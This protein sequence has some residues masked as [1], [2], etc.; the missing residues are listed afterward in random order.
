MNLSGQDIRHLNTITH[1]GKVVI[2]GTAADGT[3]YYSVKRGGFEDTALLEGAD[4]FGFEDWKKLRLG[5]STED[6]SV[7]AYEGKYLTDGAGAPLLRSVYGDS[8]EVTRSAGAPVQLVSALNHLYVFRQSPS[9]KILVSRFVLD[10]MTNELVPR[11]EVRFRRSRQRFEPQQSMASADGGSFDSLDYRDMAGKSFFEPSLELSFAGPVANGWFSAILVPTAESDRKRWHLFVYEPAAAKLVLYSVGSGANGLFDVKDYLYG[12]ADPAK[13]EGATYRSIPGILRRKID[14]QGLTVAGGPSAATYDIQKEQM[15]DAGP[16]LMRDV[17]RAMLAVPVTAGE[18]APVRTAVLD[19]ALAADGTLSQIDLSP[20]DATILRSDTREVL[21]PLSLLDDIKEIAAVSPPPAG[22]VAAMERG[23]DDQLQIRSTEPLPEVLATGA[24]VKLRGSQSY[25]GHYKVLSV[26]GTTFEVAATFQSGEAG[27]WEVAPEKRTGLVF[28]NMVVGT[29]KTSDGKLRVL[30]PAHDLKAGDEVQI[31]GTEGYDGIF[32]VTSIDGEARAFVLDAPFFTGEAANLSKVV[33]RGLRMDGNDRVETPELPLPLPSHDRDLGRTLS[34]WVRIDGAGGVEQR[35]IEDHG[36]MTSL[37]VGSD[38][39]VTLAVRMSDGALHTVTDPDAMPIGAWTHVAGT[40]DYVTAT[41]GDTRIALCR[42]GALAAEQLV[43]HKLPC[44]FG[45]QLIN[46]DGVNDYVEV[47]GFLN[48]TKEFTI[49]LWA[50]SET[51]TWNTHGMLASKRDAFLICPVQGNRN[52]QFYVFIGGTVFKTA[53]YT[54]DDIRIWH[55]YTGTYD[56]K[57]LRFY[58][59]GKLVQSL[60]AAGT[61]GAD[62]GVLCI[63]RDDGLSRYFSGRIAGVELWSRARSQA[64]LEAD[65]GKRWTGREAGLVGYWPLDNGTAKDLSTAK[66]HGSIKGG[67]AWK[68]APTYLHPHFALP[69]RDGARSQVMRF[70][71]YDAHIE[72]PPF[73]SPTSAITV[74][75]WARSALPTWNAWGCLASKRSA[76]M[77]HP[78]AGERKIDFSLWINGAQVNAQFTPLDIQGWHLYTGTY[79]GSNVRLYIDGVQVA[80][81][82]ASGS[83]SADAEGSLYIGHDDDNHPLQRNFKGD[84]AEVQIFDVARSQADI[85]ADMSR[86]LSGGESGLVGYWP[87]SSGPQDLSQN[88]RH[89]VMKGKPSLVSVGSMFAIGQGLSG[90]IADVQIWDRARDADTI[91]ATMHLQLTGKEEGLLANYRMGAIVYEESPP[92]VP[93]FS[94]RGLNGLVY[95]DPYAGARRLHRATGS[96][97][98][99]VQYGSDELC[100]VSQR[101]VYEESFEF[102][103]TSPDPAFNPSNAD[104]TGER[105]FAFSYWGKSSRG[106]KEIA[107]FPA[108][109]VM[110]SDFL[111][112][113]GGWYKAACRVVVPDGVS[114]MRAFEIA[115]VRGRWGQEAA[116]PESEW[117]AI[118]IRKHRI[119]LISDAVT[120]ESYTDLAALA[121]L[122]AQSQAVLDNLRSLRRAEDKVSRF[123]TQIVDLLARIDVVQNN[124]RYVNERNALVARVPNLESQKSVATSTLNTLLNDPYNYFHTLRVKHSQMVAD[125][126]E[127]GL[128]QYTARGTDNQL[129]QLLP[130]GDGSFK[131][132]CKTKSDEPFIAHPFMIVKP[133]PDSSK[134]SGWEQ[135]HQDLWQRWR[136]VDAGDGYHYVALSSDSN[137]VWDVK[138]A[139][140]GQGTEVMTWSRNGGSHQRW[141]RVKTNELLPSA[142]DVIAQQNAV[143]KKFADEIAA[144]QAR[145]AWLNEALA[146]NETLGALQTQLSTA[147]SSLNTARTELATVNTVLLGALGQAAP[148]TMPVLATDDRDLVTAGAVLDFVQPAGGVQLMES[149]EG[150]VLLSYIDTQGRMRA[151]AYDATADSRNAAFEQWSPD[152][153]RA[154]ADIRDSGDKIS[155]AQPVSLPSY[156]WTCE[157]FVQLPLATRSDGTPY[158]LSLVAAADGRLDAPLAV[159]RGSRLGLLLDGWFFDCGADLG[160][161]LAPGWHHLAASTSRG[162]TSFYAN[163]DLV[164]SCKTTQPAL[165]FNGTSDYVEVP[166]FSNPTS[167]M[168]VSIWARSATPTWNAYGCLVSK[169]DAFLLHPEQDSRRISFYVWVSGA[170]LKILSYTP[171]DIQGWH[172][173]T[174]TFDGSYM[175]LYI[176]GAFAAELAVSGTIQADP[177]EMHIGHD[178]DTPPTQRLFGGEIAEVALWNTARGPSEVRE[179]FVR[180]LKG[181]ES[182]LAGYWRMDKIEEGGTL[183]VKDLTSKAHHGLLRGA[184]SDATITT[185]GEL[186]VKVLGNA[187][188]GG[189]P[190]GRLAEVR[191]WNL[192]LSDAEVAAHARTACSGS[193]PGLVG[194]WPLDEATG[195]T[196]RD[197]AAGGELHGAMIGVDWMGCTANIGNPGARV[198]SLPERGNAHLLC[199]NVALGS[200]SFTFECWARRSGAGLGAPQM[201]A[202]MGLAATGKGFGFGFRES[203][204]LT[205]SFHNDDLTSISTYTDTDW[206]HLCGTYDQP[207]KR[208][209]LYVDGALVA[210]RTAAADYIG[211]GALHI[212]KSVMTG[213]GHFAGDLAEVRIWDKARS[214]DEIR[215][216]MRLRLFGTEENLLAHYPMDEA[217]GEGRVRDKK[218]GDWL[219]QLSGTAKLLLSTSLPMAGAN[220]LI[221]AE[222]SSVEVSGEGKKQAL[223]R[224]FSGYASAGLVVLVPEQ[225]VEELA[226]QWVGNTQISPTLLGYIEGPPPVPSENFT[227]ED[228]YDGAATITLSQSDETSYTFQRSETSTSAFNLAAFIGAEW[229][230]ESGIGINVKMTSGYAGAGIEFASEQSV[231][232]DTTLSAVSSLLSSDSLTLMGRLEERAACPAVGKRWVPKNVGY[233]LVV[234]GMADVFVTK[235]KRSGRMVSYEIRPV[236]GVPLD[237]NTITFMLNPAYVLNGSLDGLVGSMPADSIF[238]AHVPEMRAQYGSLYPASYFRLKDAYARKQA[239]QEQDMARDSF[240]Y[241]FSSASRADPADSRNAQDPSTSEAEGGAP[242]SEAA[243]DAD[244]EALQE[245]NEEKKKEA[246]SDSAKRREE[247][248]KKQGSIEGRTRATGA[249]EEWQLR[250]ANIRT[251]AGKRN[252][253]NTYVWDADGGLRAEE[254]SFANTVEHSFSV[255]NIFSLSGGVSADFMV[256]GFKAAFSLLGG[257]SQA[258]ANSRTLG[259][260]RSLELTVDLSGVE[261]KGVTDLYDNPIKPGEKVDRYRFMTFYLENSTDHFSDFWSY[262]VDPEWLMSNDEEARALRQARNGRPN[263]CWRVMHRVTYVERPAL[264]VLG[265]DVRTLAAEEEDEIA[266]GFTVLNNRMDS[267][268]QQLNQVLERLPK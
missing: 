61:V 105:L 227:V 209:R 111:S 122:P 52:V 132:T 187:S 106:S 175:R 192:G 43:R 114:L 14:L 94:R 147:Q 37:S 221:A 25:D 142:R 222:Y 107:R 189:C 35:L 44:Q 27:T 56:G 9:S 173:Y 32:P 80:Q 74:S 217:S 89:G 195:T 223:M 182:G 169:R 102:R 193:E 60:A 260:S 28:D 36:G 243:S 48:P 201:I 90:E 226:L 100:A 200:K 85:Q 24:R 198:L 63:G 16:Q 51:S 214:L 64:E 160:G 4:P 109:S 103:V 3:L 210:E 259:L 130:M 233:A 206:H 208:Q 134:M 87:L 15:T 91:K 244:R 224:R 241:N 78:W 47:P 150:N 113:G 242:K 267:L 23:E 71:G 194:Y 29:E 177:G 5:E 202:T 168:T 127:G 225:R 97:M 197:R 96:G 154:C 119:R 156:G 152:A 238:H 234:S 77:F 26:D 7:A 245:Q 42:D 254:E 257:K 72:V 148:A 144:V 252:I 110:Q 18:G 178:D 185:Q 120:R 188:S 112:L 118:D 40:V 13:P 137:M 12:Q 68:T 232:R 196:A 69:A 34:A 140:L 180:P 149:C 38:N 248:Q 98:K 246:K 2:V 11:L 62:T 123:E 19:F 181:D 266:R 171:A 146:G 261:K 229:E 158:D 75:L 237:V 155:L 199:P 139:L 125:L 151:I 31:S 264:K 165:R 41:A 104:G 46:F 50:R 190:I 55:C 157:A 1:D 117:T 66:R 191:L 145:V 204:T 21:T 108:G 33:R 93:D 143:I 136:F 67:G 135:N 6:A 164:G 174:G 163:G 116:P 205:L 45:N 73:S 235:L 124:Q 184:P 218:S 81:V 219:G 251:R 211:A 268:Q 128:I 22:I 131:I 167:A 58:V 83:L 17:M 153:V 30:C 129:F 162:K 249:F 247:I 161:L 253:V 76:F 176:D 159:R 231:S 126:S 65:L 220:R 263:P 256:A 240:F 53:P 186:S 141:A 99:V 82:A 95:G 212:G 172:L 138:G 166:A 121:A 250:M 213:S 216:T 228:D 239:I 236:D 183:K 57:S 79:D 179:D 54:V 230:V 258:T 10:G 215:S 115:E 133:S 262:V 170:G 84:I 255:E 86:R 8:A 70:N 88:Q 20:D 203:S 49:S 207:T 92:I 39:R 265:T 101:G 59:D